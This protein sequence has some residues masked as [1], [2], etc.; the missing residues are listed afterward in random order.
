[1][2]AIIYWHYP[3]WGIVQFIVLNG[4]KQNINL[5]EILLKMTMEGVTVSASR[6]DQ[7][8]GS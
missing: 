7:S 8:F 2:Q 4:I 6:T 3:V 1:M 5:R